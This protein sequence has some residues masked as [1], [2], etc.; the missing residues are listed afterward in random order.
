MVTNYP[1]KIQESALDN[2]IVEADFEKAA[3][4]IVKLSGAS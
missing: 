3:E 2:L 4:K 1:F